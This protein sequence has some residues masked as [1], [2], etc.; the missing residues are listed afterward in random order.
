[1][2]PLKTVMPVATLI[3]AL[4]ASTAALAHSDEYLDNQKSPNGGQ[5]RMAGVYHLELVVVRDS[6][7]AKDNPVVVHVTDHAGTKVMTTG[8]SGMATI[9]AGKTKSTVTLAPDGDNRLKGIG[10]YASTADMKAIVS[11][12]FP[13]KTAEQARFTPLAIPAATAQ[14]G[15][16]DHKH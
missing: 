4:L 16:L 9:L 10:R 5:S 12:S 6:K 11:I 15:H 3:A 14:D 8:A 1:M 7:E 2:S 13:G